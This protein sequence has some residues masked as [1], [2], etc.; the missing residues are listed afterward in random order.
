MRNIF[1]NFKKHLPYIGGIILLAIL[2]FYNF[3][4][5]Y[6][7]PLRTEEDW[8]SYN[9]PNMYIVRE[10]LLNKDVPLWNPRTMGGS[11]FFAKP[12]IPVIYFSSIFLLLTNAWLGLKLSVIF[13]FIIAGLGMYLLMISLKKEDRIAF[14]S[15]VA[16]MFSGYIWVEMRA[17]HTNAVYA[18]AWVPFI[19]LFLL[20]AFREKDWLANSILAGIFFS[21]QLLGG[22]PQEFMNTILLFGAFLA[23]MS[24]GRRFPRR[25]IKTS[26]IGIAVVI[27]IL[28]MV[29]F[30]ILPGKEILG[31]SVRNAGYSYEDAVGDPVQPNEFFY[32]LAQGGPR[33]VGLVVFSLACFSLFD[34]KKKN[35]LVF[36][37]L[38]IFSLFIVS[39]SFVYHIIW[40]Y[41]PLY[42]SIDDVWKGIFLFSFPASVL[43][44]IG[45]SVVLSKLEKKFKLKVLYVYDSNRIEEDIDIKKY[46]YSISLDSVKIK[47]C[48]KIIIKLFDEQFLADVVIIEK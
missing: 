35:T 9:G 5:W 3:F 28:G 7:M 24:I 47:D 29:A 21:F 33:A 30:K 16:Y 11:P 15:A 6:D 22:G 8:L 10:S 48:K 42:R 34:Y 19:F 44:G 40:K 41:I 14:I 36:W 39:G 23:L 38:A 2:V 46:D 27:V 20:R 32:E 18:Y 25:L 1:M 43:A 45:S 26:L 31:I 12:Q 4:S 13:H 17:G 37:G